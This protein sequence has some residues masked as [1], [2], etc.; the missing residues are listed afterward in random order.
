MK[1]RIQKVLTVPELLGD[2]LLYSYN[3]TIWNTGRVSLKDGSYAL[4]LGER[5]EVF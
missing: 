2:E 4:S 3:V 1:G 5:W